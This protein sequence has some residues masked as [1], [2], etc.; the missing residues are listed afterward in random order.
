MTFIS[1][2]LASMSG[3]FF[4]SGIAVLLGGKRKKD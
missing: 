1:Y 4:F 2:A 3:V